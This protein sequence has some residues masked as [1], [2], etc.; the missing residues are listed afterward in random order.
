LGDCYFAIYKYTGRKNII[1][2]RVYTTMSDY[3]QLYNAVK[4]QNSSLE[5]EQTSMNQHFATDSQRVKYQT[6]D[7]SYYKFINYYLRWIYYIIA[8]GVVYVVLVGKNKGFTFRNFFIV[9]L[10][11]LFPYIIATIESFVYFILSYLYALIFRNVY[12][13]SK[14]DMPSLSLSS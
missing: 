12:L 14:Y 3:Q 7:I 10:V 2:H 5:N 6:D 9:L 8:L 13:K 1:G 4:F 11:F